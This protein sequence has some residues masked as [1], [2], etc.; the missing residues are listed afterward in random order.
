MKRLT[1]SIAVLTSLA[2]AVSASASQG[3]QIRTGYGLPSPV[4]V[5]VSHVTCNEVGDPHGVFGFG[6][7]LWTIT[8]VNVSPLEPKPPV[9]HHSRVTATWSAPTGLE[10]ADATDWVVAHSDA[11]TKE[12]RRQVEE[13]APGVIGKQ[14]EE[15]G[16]KAIAPGHTVH[17]LC[18]S[19]KH[20]IVEPHGSFA[21]GQI[22]ITCTRI[23]QWVEVRLGFRPTMK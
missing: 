15:Q 14:A 22:W 20:R 10:I 11:T 16:D 12:A 21:Q 19:H 8:G 3:C 18:T 13:E 5:R 17:W 4:L 6:G 9:L 7:L 1:L 23:H 2:I